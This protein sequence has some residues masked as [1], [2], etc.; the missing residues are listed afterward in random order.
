MMLDNLTVLVPTRN[1]EKNIVAFLDSLPGWVPLVVVD[2]SDDST[3]EII[4][5]HRPEHTLVIRDPGG[6]SKARQLGA[7]AAK[8]SWLL[9]TDADVIFPPDYFVRLLSYN[10]YDVVYGS[11]LS[12]S[13]FAGYYHWFT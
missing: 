4:Q 10:G 11:K 2:A 5:A 9:F 12:R 3:P 8:T 6:I 7:E 1:E 13:K